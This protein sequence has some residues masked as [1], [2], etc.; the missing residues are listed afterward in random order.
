MQP[1]ATALASIFDRAGVPVT[2][3]VAPVTGTVCRTAPEH[4]RAALVALKESERDFVFL[5]DTFGIDTGERIDVVYHLRSFTRDEDVLLKAAHEYDS[6]Y[7]SVWD[8][9]PSALMPEREMCELFGMLLAGHPNPKRLL[10]TD[11][12]PPLLRKEQ[13]IRTADEVRDRDAFPALDRETM[14][15]TVGSL[16]PEGVGATVDPAALPAGLTRAPAGVDNVTTEHLLL[17]MGPQHPSTHGVL[18]IMLEIDGEEI[19]TGEAIIG[20]L[21]RGIEKLAESRRFS[22]V[23]TLMDRGDYVS[24]I[25]NELAFALATEQ[26]MEIEVPRRA[27]WLRVLTGEINRIASH[28]TW[29]GPMGLDTG[30]MGEFLYIFRDREVLLD[31]LEDLTGQRMMFNYVR[32]GGVLR[33]MTT[34]AEKKIRAF[35]DTYDTYLEEHR[36]ILL[37]NEIFQARTRGLAA[38]TPERA[39]AFGLTGANLRASGVPWDVRVDRPYAAY[40]EMDFSVPVATE[41]DVYARC[42][43]RVEEMRQSARMIRQCIDGLPEGEHTAKVAKVLRPPAGETYAAVESPRGELGVHLVTDGTDSPYRMR[44]RPPAMY[45]LQAGESMLPGALLADGVVLM[46]SMDVVLGEIDR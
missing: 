5:V 30:A 4:A 18:R 39:I 44:Y 17:S 38:Y 9:F 21:H 26:I 14:R 46:G 45:A 31:I 28:A 23:G 15:R 40:P 11:G 37:D 22:A 16:A 29:Y 42:Q 19:V 34:T 20:H 2:I 33:D 25:H 1:D 43:V 8:I 6:V 3:D 41:G 27:N 32:P 12:I 35:L 10:T 7:V 13:A 36:A 24:G